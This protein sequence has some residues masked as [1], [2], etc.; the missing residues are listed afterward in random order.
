MKIRVYLTLFSAF[1]A[2][3]FLDAQPVN[4]AAN[5]SFE[6]LAADPTGPGEMADAIKWTNCN[7]Q[8]AFPYGTP[9]LFSNAGSGGTQWPN[10]FAGT[11]VPQSGNALA[12]FITSNFFVADFREYATY[13]LEAAMVPGQAYNV[14]FWLTNGSAN[15]YGGRGSNNIGVALTLASP[16]QIQHEPLS[17]VVPQLE[18]TTIIHHTAWQ[19][20]TFTFTPTQP[21]QFLTIG[22]FRNDA[23]TSIGTF[24]PGSGVAYYFLD[25]VEVIPAAPLPV[26]TL[27]LHQVDNESALELEWSLPQS[28][29]G[30]ELML[31]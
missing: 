15:W 5:G 10:T 12:G 25:N 24:T 21:F 19:Q 20:Y 6:I 16:V 3:S 30:D 8:V 9:D 22:N 26:E 2:V 23:A 4:L 13:H 28:T 17:S 7:G 31:E 1:V 11:V 27:N 14:S 18:L 29:V